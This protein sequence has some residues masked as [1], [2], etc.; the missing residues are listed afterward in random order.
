MATE[1]WIAGSGAGLTWASAFGT[2]I[3]S[4]ANGN[5]VLSSVSITNGTALDMFADFSVTAGG[6][7]TSA[8][9]N[10]LGLYLLPLNQDGSVYGDGVMTTT[11]GAYV[12][13]AT[14]WVGNLIV[15]AAAST[16]VQGT[17]TRIVLPPGTFSFAA[18]S[19]L[20]ATAHSTMTCKYRT[21]NRSIA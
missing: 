10:F 3:N 14:Y 4:I 21:Y 17:L 1:K 9:P 20:G 13:P 18:Y 15:R 5:S 7:I 16:T 6:T 8:A 19:Q 12:P 2:E 11:A